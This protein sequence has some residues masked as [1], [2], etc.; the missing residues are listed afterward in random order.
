MQFSIQSNGAWSG[1]VQDKHFFDEK[2]SQEILSI[3][4]EKSI[5]NCVDFGCGMGLYAKFLNDNDIRCECFDGNPETNKITSGICETLDLSNEFD[6]NT[7]Y[8]C[9]IS[10]E[11]GEHIPKEYEEIFIRNITKHV[12][13][14]L[15][16]S[17]AIPRQVGNGH[18]NLRSNDYIIS[19]I[20]NYRLRYNDELSQKLRKSSQLW[21]FK[22]TIMVFNK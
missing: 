15:I 7:K 18:V 1:V 6:L 4:K 16:L 9:V 14:L 5:K 21:W 17:W 20:N 13:Q 2:L 3:L 12:G 10:L 8:D 22:N 19:T 11:V